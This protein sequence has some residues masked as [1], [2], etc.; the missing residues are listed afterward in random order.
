MS[1]MREASQYKFC[2]YIY[3]HS[4]TI[5]ISDLVGLGGTFRPKTTRTNPIILG[6]LS[7][8][9]LNTLPLSKVTTTFLINTW[10]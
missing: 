5:K 1:T 4:Q 6:P 9:K 8:S 2:N 7:C 10:M 3:M